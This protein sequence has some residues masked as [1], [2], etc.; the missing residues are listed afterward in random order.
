MRLLMTLGVVRVS[1]IEL[2]LV[3]V[4]VLELV[5][6][7]ATRLAVSPAPSRVL[8]FEVLKPTRAPAR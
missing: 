1:V 2:V 5:F 6:E 4:L 8:A 7:L 3:L